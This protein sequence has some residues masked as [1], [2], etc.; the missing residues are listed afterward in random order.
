MYLYCY[1]NSVNLCDPNGKDAIAAQIYLQN[2]PMPPI[3]VGPGVS[4]TAF[5]RWK[6]GLDAAYAAPPASSGSSRSFSTSTSA[7]TSSSIIPNTI[8]SNNKPGKTPPSS[9]PE[10]PKNLGGKK[11]SW[12]PNGSY[13]GKYGETTW[14]SHSHGSG[15]DR[16]NGPQDGHWDTEFGGRFNRDGS[17][18]IGGAILVTII[19]WGIGITAAPYTGGGSMVLLAF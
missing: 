19:F 12:N 7:N 6:A 3:I 18:L 2:N 15:V 4:N 10:I 17:Q 16:G 8:L 1:N 11:P 14:D 9:W 5:N 13:N